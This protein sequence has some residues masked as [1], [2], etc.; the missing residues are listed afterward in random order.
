M[1]FQVNDLII[2][3]DGFSAAARLVSF[4]DRD[5]LHLAICLFKLLHS[6]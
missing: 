1:L 6:S 4:G 3:V 2:N 5:M